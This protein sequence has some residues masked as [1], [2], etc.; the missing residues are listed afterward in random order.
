VWSHLGENAEGN[1]TLDF[2]AQIANHDIIQLY[3][4]FIPKGLIP[5]E[6]LFDQNDVFQKPQSISS[7]DD[8]E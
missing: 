8:V 3:N 1:D 4:N 6:N 7:E 5:L 2:K